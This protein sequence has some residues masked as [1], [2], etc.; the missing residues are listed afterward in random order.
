MRGIEAVAA[1]IFEAAQ[2]EIL[3]RFRSLQVRE[4][5]EK[6]PGDLVTVAD[7][8]AEQTL[9]RA[10]SELL[11]GS[12]LVGKEAVAKYPKLLQVLRTEPVCWLGDPIDVTINFAHGVPLFATMVALVIAGE[13]VCGWI[14]APVLPSWPW[15][16]R[17]P[18]LF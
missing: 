16:K 6:T 12:V 7:L 15:P 8:E 1:A 4:I 5:K 11:P 10:L 18:V 2:T 17:V 14:Y 9:N 13:T 3:P